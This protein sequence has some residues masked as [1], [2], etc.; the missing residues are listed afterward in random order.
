MNDILA[1]LRRCGRNGGGRG[2]LGL[3]R[4]RINDCSAQDQNG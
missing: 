3:R 1:R 4:K 2:D